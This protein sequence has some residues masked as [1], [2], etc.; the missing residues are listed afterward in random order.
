MLFTDKRDLEQAIDKISEGEFEGFEQV[1]SKNKNRITNKT[2]ILALKLRAGRNRISGVFKGIFSIATLLSNFDLRLSYYSRKTKTLTE[3]M[4]SMAAGVF[5]ASEEITASTTEILNAHNELTTAID[6]I[7]EEASALNNNTVKSSDILENIKSENVEVISLSNNMKN[8]VNN[9]VEV[10]QKMQVVIEG[11]YGISKQTNLLALNA[12]IEAARAGEAGKGFS[13]VANEIRH[14][15][16][17]TKTLLG[18][19]NSLLSEVDEASQKSS[20]SVDKTVESINMVN[21]DI[22]AMSSIMIENVDY[23]NQITENLAH[24]ATYNEEVNASLEEVAAVMVTVNEEAQ[25]VSELAITME[26]IGDSMDNMSISMK[27]I[28]SN[29]EAIS[30]TSGQMASNRLYGLGNEDFIK[31]INAAINAHAN[32]V[33]TLKTNAEKMKIHPI[34]TDE[35]K[36]GFGHFYYSVKP[37]SPKILELW[38]AVEKYHHDFHKKGDAV[39]AGIKDKNAMITMNSVKEAEAISCKMIDIFNRMIEITNDMQLK[40]EFVF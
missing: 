19:M 26:D 37:T 17:T 38:N 1:N 29:L 11:I 3:K 22:E 34:Q 5:T 2:V 23:I 15:S 25:A 18:S 28:E 39:S 9:L 21:S 27:E 4:S 36:C 7:S 33:I 24:I 13:V 35:H 14:L 30:I 12:S 20:V 8:E 16:D 40:G 10:I 6:K 31:T 32:W